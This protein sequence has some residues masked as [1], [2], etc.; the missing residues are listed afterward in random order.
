MKALP[1]CLE[2]CSL[3]SLASSCVWGVR[4]LIL[5]SAFV[6]HP[7]LAAD[8]KVEK[9]SVFFDSK[10][11]ALSSSAF[12]KLINDK[13]GGVY[14]DLELIVGACFGG[15]IATRAAGPKGFLGDW[16]VSTATDMDHASKD[17]GEREGA[18]NFKIGDRTYNGYLAAWINKVN[19]DGNTVGNKALAEY[20]EA[21]KR[22]VFG[23]TVGDPQYT[24]SGAAADAMTV[25]GG[26]KSN[27][28]ILLQGAGFLD[29]LGGVESALK[30]AGYKDD[31]ITRLGVFKG[32]PDLTWDNFGKALDD[33]RKKLDENPKEEKV[34]I[35]VETHGGVK[36][37]TVAYAPGQFGEVGGGFV[38]NALNS[39]LPIHVEDPVVLSTL[40]EGLLK[41][42]GGLFADDPDLRRTGPAVL[43]F[44]TLTESF[45]HAT[46]VEIL[47]NDISIGSLLMGNPGG[48]DYQI[49]VSGFRPFPGARPC[50]HLGGAR[51]RLQP[52]GTR[53]VPPCYGRRLAPRRLLPSGLWHRYC[54]QCVSVRAGRV[55]H[56]RCNWRGVRCASG[57]PPTHFA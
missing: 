27:H 12:I 28:A 6:F 33:L 16:S 29:L 48:S 54:R 31:E 9:Q 56:A 40:G 49:A 30:S 42:G 46:S 7:A 14:Q 21:E 51:H 50:A 1:N 23:P 17:L 43:S 53:L 26:S 55:V 36:E 22:K 32:T 2:A 5:A 45:L 13:L 34:L 37:L 44:S 24:S 57:S 52:L 3:T 38:L 47:V 11:N 18:A 39:T 19:T 41:P 25:Y 35:H 4:F 10:K 15:E 8:D 20:A